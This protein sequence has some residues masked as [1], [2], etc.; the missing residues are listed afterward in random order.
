MPS[1]VAGRHCPQQ[2]LDLAA[3]TRGAE[4]GNAAC[5]AEPQHLAMVGSWCGHALGYTICGLGGQPSR[6]H[7]YLTATGAVGGW[8]L[9]EAGALRDLLCTVLAA[10][11]SFGHYQAPVVQ[12][13]GGVPRREV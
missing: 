3:R 5:G 13:P 4:P 9:G 7:G 11:F 2:L 6:N 1:Q 12:T 10:G 8:Q